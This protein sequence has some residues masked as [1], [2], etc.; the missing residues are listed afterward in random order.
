MDYN[1]RG[2]SN[3]TNF[4]DTQIILK[5]A[6][7]NSNDIFCDLGCGNGNVCRWVSKKVNFVYGVEEYKKRYHSAITNIKKFRTTNVRILNKSYCKLSTLKKLRKGTIFYCTNNESLGFFKKFEKIMPK[8]VRFVTFYLPPYPI[9][10]KSYD[11]W[12]YLMITPF[13]LAKN[14]NDWIKSVTTRK[15]LQ[16]LITE[17]KEQFPDDYEER[18]LEL[19]EDLTGIEWICNKKK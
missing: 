1:Q 3:V 4:K 13:D 10:P 14:K 2:R 12:Y 5:L 11:E 8:N 18:I 6:E 15:S 9:K 19:E 7:V 16:G 17:I